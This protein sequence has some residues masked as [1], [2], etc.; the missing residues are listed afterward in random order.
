MRIINFA[1]FNCHTTNLFNRDKI[2]KFEVVIKFEQMKIIFGYKTNSLPQELKK[3]FQENNEID[4]H[5]SRNVS[6]E[7][8]FIPQIK[9]H[10]GV[11][12]LNIQLLFYGIII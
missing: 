10:L 11:N 4:C 3:Q 8:T 1:H 6:K 9:T 7:G 12:Q 2:L 5:F